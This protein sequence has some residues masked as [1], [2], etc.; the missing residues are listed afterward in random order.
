[1]C[2]CIKGQLR[3]NKRKIYV[4][5]YPLT[6]FTSKK[7]GLEN[8]INLRPLLYALVCNYMR[9]YNLDSNNYLP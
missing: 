2:L 7:A 5:P 4:T 8:K 3:Q 1:M 9:C 6:S